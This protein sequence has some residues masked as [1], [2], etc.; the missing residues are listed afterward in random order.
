M[1]PSPPID[2]LPI[3]SVPSVIVV[4]PVYVLSAAS[5]NVPLPVFSN[6]PAGAPAVA[7]EITPLMVSVSPAP[8]SNVGSPLNANALASVRLLVAKPNAVPAAMLTVPLPKADVTPATS[9]PASRFM[10]PLKVLLPLSVRVPS[11]ILLTLPAPEITPAYLAFAGL[12]PLALPWSKVT[13]AVAPAVGANARLPRN[14]VA[15]PC[16]VPPMIVQ[17][18]LALP[19]PVRVHVLLPFFS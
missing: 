10:P 18:S 16:S 3:C 15:S 1:A 9:S 5:I 11:S 19:A 17:F 4:P 12:L 2:P 7:S 8:T 14:A 13:A 6:T